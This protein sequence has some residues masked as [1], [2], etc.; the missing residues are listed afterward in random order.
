MLKTK[1]VAVSAALLAAALL[2]LT[3][4]SA[5]AG[6]GSPRTGAPVNGPFQDLRASVAEREA[7][8]KGNMGIDSITGLWKF[9]FTIK[10]PLNNDIT[11]DS[12][13]QT[14]H[15]DGTEL[16]NSNHPPVTGSFCM[17]V[18]ERIAPRTYKVNHYAMHLG[19]ER[20]ASS[21]SGPYPAAGGAGSE[22][23][24]VQRDVFGGFARSEWESGRA[25]GGEYGG[26]PDQGRVGWCGR[27]KG[28]E[29]G[30]DFLEDGPTTVDFTGAA[31]RCRLRGA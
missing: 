2:L 11:V 19:C 23:R 9:T 20:A 29:S 13:F 31:G 16:T 25:C 4:T 26:D 21:G 18:W 22:R 1:S 15:A 24:Y 5:R 12:G 6:C 8:A 10:G 28:E 27:S 7:N 14:W 17:G 30:A 3:P